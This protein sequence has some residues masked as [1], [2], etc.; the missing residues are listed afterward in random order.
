MKKR[1]YRKGYFK[2]KQVSKYKGNSANIIYRSSWEKKVMSFFDESNNIVWWN[3]EG[4]VVPYMNPID[5]KVH[6]Y[7]PDFVFMNKKNEVYMVEI[8]P[9]KETLPPS[10]RLKR[11]NDAVVTYI[12][13]QSKWKQAIEFCKKQNWK[14]VVWTENELK[15]MKIL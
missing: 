1:N 7:F 4:I 14:F 10:K 8:K 12:I 2:P 6:S 5:R 13:N 3:S 9:Y 11:Y 15:N